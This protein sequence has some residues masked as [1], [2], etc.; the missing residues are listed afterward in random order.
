MVPFHLGYSSSEKCSKA[1]RWFLF[2]LLDM[3]TSIAGVWP[4]RSHLSHEGVPVTAKDPSPPSP[5]HE[6]QG[7]LTVT[8]VL[9]Q[10]WGQRLWEGMRHHTWGRCQSGVFITQHHFSWQLVWSL[11]IVSLLRVEARILNSFDHR[12]Q[13][14][15]VLMLTH[16]LV[17]M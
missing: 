7:L 14:C 16:H 2:P 5:S 11:H 3:A 8:E 12:I 4:A 15:P 1:V 9:Q 17:S 10:P 6:G 13:I